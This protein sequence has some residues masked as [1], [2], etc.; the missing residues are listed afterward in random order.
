M[1]YGRIHYIGEGGFI[2]VIIHGGKRGPKAF[3]SIVVIKQFNS[4]RYNLVQNQITVK[5][6]YIS[7]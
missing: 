5:K 2:V 6:P 3:Y 4:D 1:L 7:N